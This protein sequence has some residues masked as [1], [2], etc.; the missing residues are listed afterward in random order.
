MAAGG[1]I[2]RSRDDYHLVML[3]GEGQSREPVRR[4]QDWLLS[5]FRGLHRQLAAMGVEVLPF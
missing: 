4:V 3:G 2:L 1:R 5:E